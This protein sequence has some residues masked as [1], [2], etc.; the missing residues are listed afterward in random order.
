MCKLPKCQKCKGTLSVYKLRK[1]E[2]HLSAHSLCVNSVNVRHIEGHT[3]CVNSLNMSCP[4]SVLSMLQ[5]IAVC[6]RALQC[7]AVCC[8]GRSKQRRGQGTGTHICPLLSF[9]G[10]KENF[11]KAC[12]L[13]IELALNIW[14]HSLCV[15][16]RN[17]C[18]RVRVCAQGDKMSGN[19]AHS[20]TH[21]LCIYFL[22][23]CVCVCVCV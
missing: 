6:C 5:C 10:L 8:R 17:I 16:S 12:T 3:L 13:L 1:C 15:G 23:I 21:S 9:G 2:A 4:S 20:G 18:G 22:N 7:V 11:G 14:T 19:P